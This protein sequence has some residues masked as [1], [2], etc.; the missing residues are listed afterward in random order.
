MAVRI[1]LGGGEKPGTKRRGKPSVE[2]PRDVTRVVYGAVA[3][4]RPQAGGLYRP[5]HGERNALMISR[6]DQKIPWTRFYHNGNN[7]LLVF[8]SGDVSRNCR[9]EAC[10][11]NTPFYH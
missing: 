9:N 5:N 1:V 3:T 7:F 6:R 2:K 4:P 11:V 8:I 10:K